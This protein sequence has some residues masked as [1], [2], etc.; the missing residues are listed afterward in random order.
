MAARKA[1]TEEAMMGLIKECAAKLGRAP[2]VEELIRMTEGAISKNV[3]NS[4]FGNYT[5]AL[6][7]CGL[8]SS[9]P[10]TPV[11]KLD[12]FRGWAALAR[13][14]GKVP[15]ITEYMSRTKKSVQPF[16]RR[17]PSWKR[18][19]ELM[20]QIMEENKLQTEWQDVKEIIAQH[21]TKLAQ[22]ASSKGRQAESW[23][24]TDKSTGLQTG[25][26]RAGL[27]RED[28]LPM[29]GQPIFGDPIGHPAMAFAPTNEAALAILFGAM[30]REL[31]FIILRA[32][33]PCPDVVAMRKVNGG[34]Q[35]VRI[36]LEFESRNFVG[37]EHE[38]KDCD[39]I[40][41]WKH[42]WKECPLPVIELSKLIG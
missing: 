27:L 26:G 41:C 10:N 16:L 12:L 39:L 5:Q 4:R 6:Q 22:A 40:V 36:E 15:T 3:I 38:R 30:A 7:R 18:V 28:P 17:V 11:P 31:G 1:A 34:W 13:E 25:L 19:P 23:P 35:L 21:E 24:P 33:S 2:K 29:D 8:K 42:N 37:H 9:A 32:Q 14:L 20:T